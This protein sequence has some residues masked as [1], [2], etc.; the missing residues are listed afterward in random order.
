M[1]KCEGVGEARERRWLR[2]R[3][4]KGETGGGP[5]RARPVFDDLLA[6]FTAINELAARA[7]RMGGR[8]GP[9][10]DVAVPIALAARS[11]TPTPV[12]RCDRDLATAATMAG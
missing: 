6:G 11:A 9:V 3:A 12:V 5:S 4:G 2:E 8:G 1:R 10:T 7:R